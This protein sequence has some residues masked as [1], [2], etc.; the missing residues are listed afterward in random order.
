MIY[1]TG[2]FFLTWIQ[3]GTH[4]ATNVR[5]SFRSSTAVAYKLLLIYMM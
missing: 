2:I 1:I 3:F 5:K 4:A